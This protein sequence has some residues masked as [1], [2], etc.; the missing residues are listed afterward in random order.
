MTVLTANPTTMAILRI[1][2]DNG[3]GA[4]RFYINGALVATH[5]TNIPAAATRLGYHVGATLSAATATNVYVDYLRVWS[6]DPPI[7]NFVNL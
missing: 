4:V 2:V 1:E 7:S 6:D 5:T 3:A